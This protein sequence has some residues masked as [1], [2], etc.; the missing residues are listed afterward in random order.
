MTINDYATVTEVTNVL[1]NIDLS[2]TAKDGTLYSTI[3]TNFITRVSRALDKWTNRKPGAYKVDADTTRYYDG[4]NAH[5]NVLYGINTNDNR[6]G[7]GYG[8]DHILCVDELAAAPTSVAISTTGSV[9]THDLSLATTDYILYPLNATDEGYPYT[10][11][12]LDL[13][14]GTVSTWYGFPKGVKIVGKFGYSTTT[15][16]DVKQ[17][18]L[19]QVARWWK[20]AETGFQDKVSLLDNATGLTYLNALDKD[21]QQMIAHYRKLAI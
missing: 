3:L 21:I 12:R 4:P 5:S 19:I 6:L 9:A 20:R 10:E 2:G 18:V 7:G 8:G 16:E 15:P 1:P 11:I 17:A 14:N 13:I